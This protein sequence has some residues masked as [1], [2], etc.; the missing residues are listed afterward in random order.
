[1]Y[2]YIY[3]HVHRRIWKNHSYFSRLPLGRSAH[4]RR[5]PNASPWKRRLMDGSWVWPVPM[6]DGT[7]E[8]RRR[9]FSYTACVYNP[10]GRIYQPF[11]FA[12]H[13]KGACFCYSCKFLKA[14]GNLL[15]PQFLR[16]IC[17]PRTFKTAW[18]KG[19]SLRERSIWDATMYF[20]Q[21]A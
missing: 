11:C 4:A 16:T 9:N 17:L 20:M 1:M 6:G 14:P 10:T 18:R 19:K 13:V 12:S 21:F 7:K 3:K 8:S 2:I 5:R 15:T